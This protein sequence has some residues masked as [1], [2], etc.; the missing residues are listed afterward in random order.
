MPKKDIDERIAQI[1]KLMSECESIADEEGL[2]FSIGI[3]NVYN[4]YQGEKFSSK[5][6]DVD[7]DDWYES[8]SPGWQY[9]WC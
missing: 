4:T 9:S 5:P 7:E 3:A 1:R 8:T 2:T 6:D